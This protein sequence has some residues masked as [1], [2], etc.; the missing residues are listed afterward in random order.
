MFPPA[1][2]N[3]SSFPR[4]SQQLFLFV[5]LITAILVGVSGI[6]LWY[7]FLFLLVLPP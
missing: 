6:S 7:L 5:V 1:M 3:G 2:R 4:P